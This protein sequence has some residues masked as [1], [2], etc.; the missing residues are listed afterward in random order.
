MFTISPGELKAFTIYEG[1][2]SLNSVHCDEKLR[3]GSIYGTKF[4]P[5]FPCLPVSFIFLVSFF[6]LQVGVQDYASRTEYVFICDRWLTGHDGSGGNLAT[7]KLTKTLVVPEDL[8]EGLCV[9][10]SVCVCVC[11]SAK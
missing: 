9:C 1:G 2:T 8:D 3:H 11:V 4:D 7:L 10:V 5:R 6:V